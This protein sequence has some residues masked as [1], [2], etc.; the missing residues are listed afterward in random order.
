MF[1]EW[2]LRRKRNQWA[3]NHQGVHWFNHVM[4]LHNFIQGS[5]SQKENL[6]K[7]YQPLNDEWQEALKSNNHSTRKLEGISSYQAMKE[8]E[9]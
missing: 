4:K 7:G 1:Y 2:E 3:L 5:H 6:Q 8:I 9:S